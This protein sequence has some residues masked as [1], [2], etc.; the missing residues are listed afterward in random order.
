MIR[1]GELLSACRGPRPF[2][3]RRVLSDIGGRQKVRRFSREA[4]TGRWFRPAK[5]LVWKVG[6]F[7]DYVL[8]LG[9]TVVPNRSEFS[10]FV[11]GTSK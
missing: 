8:V 4:T 6:E 1:G 3:E 9:R 7:V 2:W 5:N 11:S 10:F